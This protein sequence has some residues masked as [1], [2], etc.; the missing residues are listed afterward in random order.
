MVERACALIPSGQVPAK[1]G[2]KVPAD[3]SAVAFE[4]RNAVL[5]ES[6]E[7]LRKKDGLL[8]IWLLNMLNATPRTAVLIP[9]KTDAAGGSGPIVKDDY[10]Y[11]PEKGGWGE[12]CAL[13]SL[14]QVTRTVVLIL[15]HFVFCKG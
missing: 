4:T 5:N 6:A 14:P 1:L 13:D 7:R 8:S 2:V 3:V 11:Y 12:P 9:Y 10:C 15:R